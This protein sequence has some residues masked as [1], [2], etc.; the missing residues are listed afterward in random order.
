MCSFSRAENVIFLI[1]LLLRNKVVG[2]HSTKM[3]GLIKKSILIPF[4]G[5]F[6]HNN[7]LEMSQNFN[8]KFEKLWTTMWQGAPWIGKWRKFWVPEALGTQNLFIFQL[9]KSFKSFKFVV[10][11]IKSS[12]GHHWK[13]FLNHFTPRESNYSFEKKWMQNI[14]RPDGLVPELWAFVGT[15]GTL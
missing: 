3:V 9:W 4:F 7:I 11:S 6:M 15:I 10:L 8:F 12:N 5:T 1:I 2:C 14:D 13:K